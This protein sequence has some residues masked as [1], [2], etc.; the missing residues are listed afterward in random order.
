MKR[1]GQL[2]GGG[3]AKPHRMGESSVRGWAGWKLLTDEDVAAGQDGQTYCGRCGES[4]EALL[5]ETY[6]SVCIAFA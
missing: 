4:F 1:V 2:A 3:V 6:C 5:A